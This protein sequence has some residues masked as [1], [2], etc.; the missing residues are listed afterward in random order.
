MEKYAYIWLHSSNH[1]SGHRK[2]LCCGKTAG[3]QTL[4]WLLKSQ[5][6]QSGTSDLEYICGACIFTKLD[7]RY[8]YNFIKLQDGDEWT[9]STCLATMSNICYGLINTLSVFQALTNKVLR[10]ML[11]KLSELE[12]WNM[13]TRFPETTRE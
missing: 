2:C 5:F 13:Y 10:E 8:R 3:S 1:I 12:C 9:T 11:G 6:H 7:L 4:H